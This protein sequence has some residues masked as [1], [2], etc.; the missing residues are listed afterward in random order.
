MPISTVASESAF[1]TGG[2]VIDTYRSSLAPKTIEALNFAQNW[3][4]SKPLSMEIEECSD[5]IETLE[6]GGGNGTTS[7]RRK[8]VLEG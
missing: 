3:F 5:D 7:G 1:S 6:L 2:R 8:Q 4:W